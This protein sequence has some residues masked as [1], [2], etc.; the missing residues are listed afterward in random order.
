MSPA[1]ESIPPPRTSSPMSVVRVGVIV[2]ASGKMAKNPRPFPLTVEVKPSS[3]SRSAR[4]PKVE[5]SSTSRSV[6]TT[7]LLNERIPSPKLPLI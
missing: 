2:I 4:M 7:T 1:A 6:R 3:M 5:L